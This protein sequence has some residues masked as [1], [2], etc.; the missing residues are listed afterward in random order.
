[1]E[2]YYQILGV[3]DT[4]SEQD[5]KKAYRELARKLHPDLNPDPASAERFKRVNQAYE[6]LSDAQKRAEYDQSLQQPQFNFQGGFQGGF[7]Q[8]MHDIFDQFFGRTGFGP[9][10]QRPP[11]RNSDT[12]VQLNISL[13]EAFTGKSMQVNFQDSGQQ[14]INLWVNIPAG[15]ESGTRLRYAGNGSRV[16]PNLPPGDLIIIIHVL[17]HARWERSGAH[18]LGELQVPLWSALTG[19]EQMVTLLDNSQI[20][21]KIPSLTADGTMLRIAG[22]G[23]KIRNSTQRGDL[24]MKVKVIMPKNLTDEQARMLQSWSES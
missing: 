4:A 20:N 16:Q 13:E 22:Q 19:C 15:V 11:S 3:S 1:M 23:M 18:L 7:Q 9:F 17:P 21:V 12:V 5:I 2:N 24:H 6:T 10:G 14:H 8:N